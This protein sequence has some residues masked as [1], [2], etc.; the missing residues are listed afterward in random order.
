VEYSV[1]ALLPVRN[2][3]STLAATVME[4]LETT[5][6]LARQT[7]VVVVD[8]CSCDA[9]I[10]VADELATEYPQLTVVRHSTP[11]GMFAATCTAFSQSTGVAIFL[12]PG[13]GIPAIHEVRKLWVSL[14]DC[15]LV[16]GR[17][18]ADQGGGS[19]PTAGQVL[20]GRLFA[21]GRRRAFE[22][23]LGGIDPAAPFFDGL[24]KLAITWR[25]IDIAQRRPALYPYRVATLARRLYGARIDSAESGSASGVAGTPPAQRRRPGYLTRIREF[26]LGE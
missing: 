14:D 8:D 21:L 4:T 23:L 24:A 25:E 6:D 13:D 19:G 5:A 2:V 22:L 1:S 20:A 7:Q 26:A 18:Q 10:E 12:L 15:E 9:T 16:I 3:E 11:G 17:P